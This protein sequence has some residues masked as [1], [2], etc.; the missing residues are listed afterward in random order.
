VIGKG[1]AAAIVLVLASLLSWFLFFTLHS[2][3]HLEMRLLHIVIFGIWSYCLL[4]G[5]GWH[6]NRFEAYSL[7]TGVAIFCE[8]IQFWTPGHDPEWKGLAASLVGVILGQES[9]RLKILRGNR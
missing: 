9:Y 5:T 4:A 6:L 8:L 1:P 2:L 3:T 7:L